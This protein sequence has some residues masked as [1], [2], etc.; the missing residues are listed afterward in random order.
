MSKSGIILV[1]D[2]DPSTRLLLGHILSLEYDVVVKEDGLEAMLW[3]QGGN[4]P[5]MILLDLCMPRITGVDFIDA[6]KMSGYY[7]NIPLIIVSGSYDENILRKRLDI[8]NDHFVK[9]PFNPET[10]LDTINKKLLH[11]AAKEFT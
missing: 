5:D 4:M 11:H 8:D 6:L 9:K 1:V 7:S 2:D 10:L 3:L